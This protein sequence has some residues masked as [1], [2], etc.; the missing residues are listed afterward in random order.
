[1]FAAAHE[2]RTAHDIGVFL[3]YFC[4]L[5]MVWFTQTIYDVRYGADDIWHRWAKLSELVAFVGVKNLRLRY[6]LA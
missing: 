2:I 5:W 6:N 4:I 3:S 1:M